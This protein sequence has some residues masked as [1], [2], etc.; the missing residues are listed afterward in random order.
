MMRSKRKSE[1]A[2][3]NFWNDAFKDNPAHVMVRNPLL[4]R[5]ISSLSPGMALDLGCGTGENA[6]ALIRQGWQ[7]TGV[8]WAAHAIE[9]A[10]AA[11]ARVRLFL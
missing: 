7:V 1:V 8:D 5:I 3:M 4:E 10:A 2:D 6:T 11:R 9:L